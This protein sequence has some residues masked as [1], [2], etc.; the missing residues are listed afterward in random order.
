M[1]AFVPAAFVVRY[2]IQGDPTFLLPNALF[3]G[4]L[5]VA[6]WG[7]G[8]RRRAVRRRDEERRI[9][10][11]RE[12]ILA[13]RGWI[14][15]EVHDTVA[16][17]VT[18][19]VLHA[20]AGQRVIATD[21]EG[22][23]QCQ[24]TIEDV[25]QQAMSEL[26]ELLDVLRPAE[27]DGDTAAHCYRLGLK[28]LDALVARTQKAGVAVRRQVNGEPR[29]LPPEVDL[30]AYR[31]V[32]EALTNVIKH[33]GKGAAATVFL[34]WRG[35]WLTVQVDDDGSGRQDDR[36]NVLSTGHGLLGLGER[37]ALLGGRLQ[38]GT[39]QQGGFAI[40]A[41]LPC[42]GATTAPADGVPLVRG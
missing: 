30:A 11:G 23:R 39:A 31:T 3:F 1:A 2:S 25:S 20:S 36:S 40:T 5:V 4:A 34:T 33:C 41:D 38:V 13:E 21:I 17:A 9:A 37:V 24:S 19:I 28:D 16:H 6:V 26:R 10:A 7:H 15:Q 14:A 42:G 18:V 8:V 35:D 12:A 29:K 32:Q 27:P 22:A